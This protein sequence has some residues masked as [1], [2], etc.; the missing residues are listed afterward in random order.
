M[1]KKILIAVAGNLCWTAERL[2]I[3][4]DEDRARA[5]FGVGFMLCGACYWLLL[6][7]VLAVL[8]AVGFMAGQYWQ[9]HIHP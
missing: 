5:C 4:D 3:G 9:A 7:A 2:F 8:F 6:L 1:I